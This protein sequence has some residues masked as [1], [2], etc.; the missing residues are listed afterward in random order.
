MAD[1]AKK[2]SK[3]EEIIKDLKN[4]LSCNLPELK[5]WVNW[6]RKAEPRPESG[7]TGLP[8]KPPVNQLPTDKD[9]K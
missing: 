3:P 7:H 4:D 8:P 5:N 6:D 9:K 2:N 1:E